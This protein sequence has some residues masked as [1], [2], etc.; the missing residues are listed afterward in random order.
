MLVE[1]AGTHL[2]VLHIRSEVAYMTDVG[3][4]EEVEAGSVRALVRVRQK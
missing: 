4:E 1:R 3:D 2:V